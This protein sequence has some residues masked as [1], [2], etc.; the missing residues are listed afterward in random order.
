MGSKFWEVVCDEH[1]IGGSGEYC[2]DND[3]HLDRINV[4]SH[5][6]RCHVATAIDYNPPK[7]RR[8]EN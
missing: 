7:L 8:R 1:G 3:A 5:E 2:G 4:F 6:A